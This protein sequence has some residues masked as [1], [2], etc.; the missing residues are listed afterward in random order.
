ME[1]NP[2][3]DRDRLGEILDRLD[4][5]TDRLFSHAGQPMSQFKKHDLLSSLRQRSTVP[6]GTCTFDLPG[7]H[8]WMQQP[9]ALRT[10]AIT[11]WIEQVNTLELAISMVLQLT[12][13]S[14][15]PTSEV[16][17]DGFF[18]RSLDPSMP[19]QLIRVGIPAQLAYFAEISG[20][21]H[22][23]TV[24]FMSQPNFAERATQT[25]NPVPF[26]LT[27]CVL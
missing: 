21:K 24:R 3:V 16:A 6:G 20:G 9:A 15:T 10:E 5:L 18:Q 27:C 1:N 19:C 26:E 7:Y 14:S 8:L 12:R 17:S 13:G 23:F 2:G 25:D 11:G 4:L 22:R